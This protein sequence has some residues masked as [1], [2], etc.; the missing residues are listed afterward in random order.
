M[1]KLVAYANK[2]GGEKGADMG[3]KRVKDKQILRS[4]ILK[5]SGRGTPVTAKRAVS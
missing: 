5:E 2:A 4:L 3:R 1:K